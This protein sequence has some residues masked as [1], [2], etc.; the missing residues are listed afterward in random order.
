MI[1]EKVGISFARLIPEVSSAAREGR[2]GGL[3]AAGQK[4]S[5]EDVKRRGKIYIYSQQSGRLHRADAREKDV[6]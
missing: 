6:H 2:E 1:R 5:K 4:K 3:R